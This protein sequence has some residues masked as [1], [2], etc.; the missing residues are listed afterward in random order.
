MGADG[1]VAVHAI[2]YL[3]CR[4]IAAPAVLSLFVTIG[5]FR[6]FKDTRWVHRRPWV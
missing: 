2:T 1:D 3:R 5:T 4:A 6:G